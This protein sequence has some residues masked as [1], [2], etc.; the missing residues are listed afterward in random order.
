MIA[1][2]EISKLRGST[3][4]TVFENPENQL[5]P[6]E[7]VGSQIAVVLKK[8]KIVENNEIDAEVIRLLERVGISNASKRYK[9]RSSRFSLA[10]QQRICIAIAIAAR[11]RILLCDEP[12]HNLDVVSRINIV[13]LLASIQ[14]E[15]GITIIITTH[16]IRNVINYADRVGIIYAGQIVEIGTAKEVITNPQHPYT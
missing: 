3:M 12:V 8:N 13:N 11:P 7:T 16:D 10:E 4:G 15:M 2:Q 14:K 1:Q 9:Q 6:L 5:N